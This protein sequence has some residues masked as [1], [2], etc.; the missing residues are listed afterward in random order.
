M[1]RENVETVRRIFGMW[2]HGDFRAGAD[3]FDADVV[4]V[5]RPPFP[6]PGV[7]IGRERIGAYMRGILQQFQGLTIEAK[8]IEAVGDGVLARC[9]QH[10]R[11]RASGVEVDDSYFMLFSFRAG[12]IVRIDVVREEAEALEA[13]GL[14]E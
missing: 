11:G 10:G 3:D 9:F 6:D 14:R 8:R 2:A 13:V 4:F 7:Y 5:P 12:K 1:S